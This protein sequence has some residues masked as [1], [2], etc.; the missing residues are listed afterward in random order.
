MADRATTQLKPGDILVPVFEEYDIYTGTG[1]QVTGEEILYK[2][3]IKIAEQKLPDGDY[4]N[5]ISLV[6]ARGDVYDMQVVSFEMDNGTMK[7][8]AVVKI[9]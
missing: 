9:P 8:G 3:N 6:D 5:Y 4:M 2:E 1:T 7:N